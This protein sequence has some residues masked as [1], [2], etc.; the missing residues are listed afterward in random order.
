MG[1]CS[2]STTS[3]SRENLTRTSRATCGRQIRTG[4]AWSR[5]TASEGDHDEHTGHI[6]TEEADEHSRPCRQL[7]CKNCGSNHLV[8]NAVLQIHGSAGI[9]LYLH[10]SGCRTVG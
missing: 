7:D 10:Q 1:D 9:G 3:I 5:S 6:R 2:C 4:P 8:T